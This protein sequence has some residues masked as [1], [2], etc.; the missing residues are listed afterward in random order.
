MTASQPQSGITPGIHVALCSGWRHT[1]LIGADFLS[2]FGLLVDCRNNRLLDGVTSLSAPAQASNPR[3]PS[4]K[5]ISSGTS[6]DTLLSEFPDFTRPTGVQR[7]VRH[8]TVHHIRTTQDPPVTCRPRR[9]APDR[10]K[11][12]KAEFDA[13]V[14]DGTAPLWRL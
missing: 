10:L 6:V 5:V 2:H 14:R 13:M 4:I 7:E 3:I 12:T 8:Y 1:P 11:I 9:L